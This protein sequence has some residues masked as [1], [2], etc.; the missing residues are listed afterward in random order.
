MKRS[1]LLL[2]FVLLAGRAA[3]SDRVHENYKGADAGV[4][5][6][7][8]GSIGPESNFKFF[9]RKV[10]APSGYRGFGGDGSIYYDTRSLFISRPAD[11]T[12]HEDGQV[13]TTRLE[14]GSY[15]VY[16][17]KIVAGAYGGEIDW[18]PAHGDF[19][20]PFTIETGKA[21]YIGDFAGIRLSGEGAFGSKTVEG[22]LIIVT[23]KHER[24]IPI[25]QKQ[26]PN[27]PPVT[28]SVMDVSKLGE[29]ALLSKEPAAN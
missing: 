22:G 8:A 23:D 25:A 14:P 10:G 20:I 28:V 17:Y 13:V 3:A 19:S 6:Y 18:G 7:A 12:G 26:M 15:E 1:L 24:D 2:A 21:T 29:P 4:L 5:I 11:F 9:Y 27:L 16:T